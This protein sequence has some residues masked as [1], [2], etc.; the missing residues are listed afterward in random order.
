MYFYNFKNSSLYWG[1]FLQYRVQV[2]EAYA[3]LSDEKKRRM[4][5]SGQDL[6]DAG[7]PGYQDIDPNSIFQV[8]NMDTR[9]YCALKKYLKSNFLSSYS[10]YVLI[11]G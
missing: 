8:D 1:Y 5:D 2:G 10:C 6:D 4:Y 11:E 7:G 9:I 3:V